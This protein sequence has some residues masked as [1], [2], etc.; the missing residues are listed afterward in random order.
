MNKQHSHTTPTSDPQYQTIID[1]E[2]RS[3][4]KC[5]GTTEEVLKL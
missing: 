1:Q 5:I 4:A 2:I 3:S